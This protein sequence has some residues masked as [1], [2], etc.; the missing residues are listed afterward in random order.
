MARLAK[1]IRSY[2][3]G[4]EFLGNRTKRKLGNNTD[5]VGGLDAVHVRLYETSVVIHW[6]DGTFSLD[7][8]GYRTVTTK[9]R[10]NQTIPHGYRVYQRDNE[11][12]V[13]DPKGR[14]FTFDRSI[15]WT[16]DAGPVSLPEPVKS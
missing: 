10:I 4:I 14:E 7:D 9:D 3:D 12:Y 15:V 5:L 16:K 11:W 13:S 1:A 6:A 8:G 2:E